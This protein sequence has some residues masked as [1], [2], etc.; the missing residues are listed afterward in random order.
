MSVL[1]KIPVKVKTNMPVSK[2]PHLFSFSEMIKRQEAEKT[3]VQDTAADS[4]L[5]SKA[6]EVWKNSSEQAKDS[7]YKY[8]YSF[9]RVNK[10]L[11][12]YDISGKY[13]GTGKV[14]MSQEVQ[15]DINNMTE[16][17]SRSTYSEDMTLY[18]GYKFTN[19]RIDKFFRISTDKLKNSSVQELRNNLL[20]RRITDSGFMS[21]TAVKEKGFSDYPIQMSIKFSKGSQGMYMEPFSAH[22]E[23][24]KRNWDGDSMQEYFGQEMEVLLQRD[25]SFKISSVDKNDKGQLLIGIDLISQKP[26]KL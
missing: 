10:P 25:S 13:L 11:R 19:D 15:R 9:G 3:I 1:G 18:R 17:I 4:T 8:T 2:Q 5:R 21:T 7:V 20:G 26:K 14:E 22:G 6:G 12:G 24:A 16:M 23:G